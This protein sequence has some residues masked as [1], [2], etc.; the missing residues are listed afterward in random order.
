MPLVI[1]LDTPGGLDTSMRSIVKR[2]TASE[3]PV[4]VYVSPEVQ[5]LL[6]PVYSSLFPHIL[7]PWRRG[8]IWALLIP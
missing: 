6:Q 3:V 5:G 7:P 1:E 2:I 4:I 8:Q